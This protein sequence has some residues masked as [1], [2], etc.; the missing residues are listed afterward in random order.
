MNRIAYQSSFFAVCFFMAVHSAFGALPAR[1]VPIDASAA[2]A[3]SADGTIVA[4]EADGQAFLWTEPGGVETLPLPTD[5][6]MFSVTNLSGDGTTIVGG[7]RIRTGSSQHYEP[8]RW[9]AAGGYQPLGSLSTDGLDWAFATDV[10]DDGS[11]VVGTNDTPDGRQ[12]FRWTQETGQVSLGT[13]GSTNP[14]YPPFSEGE[15]VSAD[16]NTVV[17][18]VTTL[19]DDY[20][21]AFRWT[22]SDGYD[23]IG[24]P[25]GTGSTPAGGARAV[26]GDGLVVA[27][28]SQ[29]N[30][31]ESWTWTE[32]DGFSILPTGR[33]GGEV[34]VSNMSFDG[35]TIVGSQIVWNQPTPSGVVYNAVLW[36]KTSSGYQIFSVDELLE[37]AGVDL[38]G[39]HLEGAWDVSYDGRAIVG[40]GTN[41]AGEERSWYVAFAVPEPS[42]LVYVGL[43]LAGLLFK[44]RG[45]YRAINR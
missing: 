23:V 36:R 13:L 28:H 8:F 1:F 24:L 10:S 11:V 7:L 37:S 25:P 45:K 4:G 22:P 6:Q 44:R 31:W 5:Y 16:G 19:Q 33:S 39:W 35:S 18:F 43:A 32:Q 17:G 12:A 34:D 3:I 15:G 29:W 30:G 38:N 26:S 20:Y 40:T 2:S 21:K 42:S 27:G 41:A 9:T 14:Y